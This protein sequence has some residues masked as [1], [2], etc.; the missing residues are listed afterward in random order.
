MWS[1][2][3]NV[4]FIC[5][6]AYPHKAA[7]KKKSDFIPFFSEKSSGLGIFIL[8]FL[9]SRIKFSCSCE[10]QIAT[11]STFLILLLFDP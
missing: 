11:L 1:V 3:L 2:I 4:G 6:R 7:V 5:L 9:K 10:F 8:D